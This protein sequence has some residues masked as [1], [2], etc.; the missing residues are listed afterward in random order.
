MVGGQYQPDLFI[1][2]AFQSLVQ[3]RVFKP[4]G[5][6]TAVTHFIAGKFFEYFHFRTGMT[7][8][9]H[10]IVYDHIDVIIHHIVDIVYQVKTRLVIH[11]FGI[12]HFEVAPAKSLE[13]GPEKFF[14]ME[15]LPS[16][17]IIILPLHREFL[18]NIHG[19][20]PGE[21]GIPR[22][23]G[24]GRQDRIKTIFFEYPETLRK[25]GLYGFPLV[26]PEVI[27][28][29]EK[30]GRTFFH[31]GQHFKLKEIMTHH[32]ALLSLW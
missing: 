29:H 26:K 4:A 24:S 10:K 20:H 3:R 18:F 30:Q 9:I 2:D 7:E 28:Q 16:F 23:L 15:I 32:R 17:L 27:D 1:C 21:N 14:F 22:I 12:R 13:L 6:D 25:N 11:H 8:H 31:M 19:H 5:S